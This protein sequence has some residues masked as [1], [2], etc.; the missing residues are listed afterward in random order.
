[1]ANN[2]G[3]LRYSNRFFNGANATGDAT[4]GGVVAGYTNQPPQY[5]GQLGAVEQLSASGAARVTDPAAAQTLY[6]GEYQYVKF[7]DDST[8]YAVGQ[9]LYWKDTENYIVTNVPPTSLT[10]AGVALSIVTGGNYWFMQ[11]SGKASVK[12]AAALTTP[13]I[14]QPVFSN[15][16]TP[17][18]AVNSATDATAVLSGGAVVG[19][20]QYIGVAFVAP[21]SSTITAVVLKGLPRVA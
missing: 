3:I 17:A 5:V 18:L 6:G 15:E 11:V 9:I 12:F 21:V 20:S 14:G 10:V 7:A 4:P 16:A 19:L 2:T 8:A 1:M 13:A